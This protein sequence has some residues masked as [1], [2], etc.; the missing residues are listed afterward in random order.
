MPDAWTGNLV[1]K[2][3]NKRV[4]YDDL[5]DELGVTKSY[6]SMVMNGKR[7]PKGC[8]ERFEKAVNDIIARRKVKPNDCTESKQ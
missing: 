7:K 8:R 2:M 5:A 4:T 3:H 1:G 6:I